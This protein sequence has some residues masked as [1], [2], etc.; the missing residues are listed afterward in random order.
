MEANIL[1]VKN[2]LYNINSSLHRRSF[3]G[4]VYFKKMNKVPITGK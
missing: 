4:A 1:M 2:K 3:N